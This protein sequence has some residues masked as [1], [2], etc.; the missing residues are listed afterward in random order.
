MI[1]PDMNTLSIV[2]QCELVSISRSVFYY[3]GKGESS[4]NLLLMR[5][6]DEQ[7]DGSLCSHVCF[8]IWRRPIMAPGRWH[9]T[10]GAVATAS[11]ASVY[12]G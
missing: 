10:F 3:E 2:R 1:D 11:P 5:L 4:F 7:F 12:G 6:I 9:V 8:A